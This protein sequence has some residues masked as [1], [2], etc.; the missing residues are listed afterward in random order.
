MVQYL[1]EEWVNAVHETASSS[2]SVRKSAG[3]ITIG[4]TQQITIDGTVVFTYH[5]SADNGD[6]GFALG[7]A[8]PEDVR[9]VQSRQTAVKV[10]TGKLAA[11]EAFVTGKIKM[12][13]DQRKLVDAQPLFAALEAVFDRVRQRTEYP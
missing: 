11:Q 10:A 1:S 4:V 12:S 8:D 7:A 9:F 5:L 13:G 3:A 6:V 2:P